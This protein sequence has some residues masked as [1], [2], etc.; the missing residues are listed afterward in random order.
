M[1]PLFLY[2]ILVVRP[3]AYQLR[4]FLPTRLINNH[5]LNPANHPTLPNPILAAVAPKDLFSP[6][7]NNSGGA[8]RIIAVTPRSVYHR[9]SPASASCAHQPLMPITLTNLSLSGHI[10]P[11]NPPPQTRKAET[12]TAVSTAHVERALRWVLDDTFDD[13]VYELVSSDNVVFRLSARL[14][15]ALPACTMS[16]Q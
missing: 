4:V 2:C 13:G 9:L 7:L 16:A 15:N 6:T 11:P 8:R 1:Q 14:F 10:R 3:M 12:G 5:V